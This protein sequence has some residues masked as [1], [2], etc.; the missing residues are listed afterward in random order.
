MGEL[1]D[2]LKGLDDKKSELQTKIFKIDSNT[3]GDAKRYSYTDSNFKPC[4]VMNLKLVE[5]EKNYQTAFESIK[6]ANIDKLDKDGRYKDHPEMKYNTAHFTTLSQLGHSPFSLY[7]SIVRESIQNGDATI[8]KTEI[9]Q[10]PQ[11]IQK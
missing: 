6:K 11:F 5:L 3:E 9:K 8:I 2:E 7:D 4:F 10:V 1:F